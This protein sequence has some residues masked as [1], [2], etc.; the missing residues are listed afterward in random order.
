MQSRDGGW[1]RVRRR[2]SRILSQQHPV[3]R[4]RRAARSADRGRHRALRLDA[5]AARRDAQTSKPLARWRRLSAPHAA[6]GGLVVRPLGHELHLRHLVGAVRAECRRRRSSGPGD[7]QGGRLAAC[8]SRTPTA[9]GARTRA[10]TSSTTSGYEPAPSTASQTAWALLGLMAAGEVDHPASGA[11]VEYLIRHTD[12]KRAV[13]RAALHGDGLSARVLSALS[14]LFEV[15]PAL[16]AGAVPEFEKHQQQGGRGRNVILGAGRLPRP[17]WN[18][19]DPRPVLIVT[20]L[21]QEARIAA[22]PGMTVICSSSDPQQLRALL[23]GFDPSTIRG[24]ISFGVAGGLDPDPADPATSWSRPM[25]SPVRSAGWPA[26]RSASELIAERRPRRSARGPRQA[27]RRRAGRGRAGRQ[28][29]AAHAETGASAVDMESHIAADYATEA[30]LAVCCRCASS[31]IP[32]RERLPALATAR[33]Q[34]ERQYRSA[35]GAGRPC[36]KPD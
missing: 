21:V 17:W 18:S 11:G 2:Q 33:H 9:A 34:A 32:R 19:I 27:C 8:R 7:A 10:A 22:G 23:A 30:G 6:A 20:G 26:W 16:G 29:R 15:L 12:R 28:G 35:Q 3:R 36:A 25:S 24:V 13:G 4:P 31:A 14:R 1:A 5:G